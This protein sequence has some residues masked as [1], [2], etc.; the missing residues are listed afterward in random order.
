MVYHRFSFVYYSIFHRI[1]EF[2]LILSTY[3]QTYFLKTAF[4]VSKGEHDRNVNKENFPLLYLRSNNISMECYEMIFVCMC[5]C[6]YYIY[7]T[8]VCASKCLY[9]PHP[10]RS[11]IHI[12][13]AAPPIGIDDC[14][15][16]FYQSW[17]RATHVNL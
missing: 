15:L 2:T 16:H 1:G 17:K 5:I 6:T 4:P 8:S 14:G 10:I 12:Q 7:V 3:F 13:H 9:L 11:T